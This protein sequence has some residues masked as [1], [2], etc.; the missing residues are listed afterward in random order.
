[1]TGTQLPGTTASAIQSHLDELRQSHAGLCRG[2]VKFARAASKGAS[3][4]VGQPTEVANYVKLRGWL[5]DTARF[6]VRVAR[7]VS[8]WADQA[9]L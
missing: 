9:D 7:V 5:D 8:D 2:L 1:M 3:T 6:D 4:L